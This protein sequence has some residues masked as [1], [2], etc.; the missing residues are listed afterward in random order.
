MTPVPR[1]DGLYGRLDGV[2]YAANRDTRGDLVVTSDDPATLE[3]GFEDRYGVGRY[4]RA[5]SPGELD[6]LFSV[7]HEG[8]FRGAEVSVA[9]NARGRVLV[10]T[11]R[12]DLAHTLD[13]PRVDKGWW[14]REIDL[15]DPDL[16]IR[17]VLEQHPV[18][19]TE[20]TTD[21]DAGIDPD[22][23]FAQFG[24]DRT[25]NGLLRRHVTPAGFEDQVLR[26]VDVWAPDRHASVQTA[27]INALESPLEEITTDQACEFEQMVAQRSYRPF[28]S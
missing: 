5:V 4:T 25:P 12:A 19:G 26:D 22:R 18:G 23:Y 10:G 24:P 11:S 2:L 16:V 28:S 7:S 20:N 8:T 6:E 14:E 9:V 17:E 21:A 13:L 15:D 1:P 27:I 3:R